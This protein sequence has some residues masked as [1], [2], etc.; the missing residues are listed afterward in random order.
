MK[1]RYQQIEL[2][3]C[4]CG[5][6]FLR[7]LMGEGLTHWYTYYTVEGGCES[8]PLSY[9]IQ[10]GREL[11]PLLVAALPLRVVAKGVKHD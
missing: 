11:D 6:P 7:L 8:L 9:C 10:C 3:A 1:V 2:V 4:L 5:S